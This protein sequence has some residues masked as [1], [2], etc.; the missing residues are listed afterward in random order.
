MLLY[1]KL[2]IDVMKIFG[3]YSTKQNNLLYILHKNLNNNSFYTCD[4]KQI[5]RIDDISYMPSE[6]NKK[7]I[8]KFHPFN[9]L[10]ESCSHL[11]IDDSI[12]LYL[13]NLTYDIFKKII[14][15]KDGTS[16]NHTLN[17]AQIATL[18][19]PTINTKYKLYNLFN[20]LTSTSF[21]K[22]LISFEINFNST[23]KDAKINFKYSLYE[24]LKSIK[25]NMIFGIH[26]EDHEIELFKQIYKNYIIIIINDL[27]KETVKI[28]EKSN[29]HSNFYILLRIRLMLEE[30]YWKKYNISFISLFKKKLPKYKKM[31]SNLN[32]YNQYDVFTNFDSI[33]TEE[34]RKFDQKAYQSEIQIRKESEPNW[35]LLK[36]DIVGKNKQLPVANKDEYI[37]HLINDFGQ[38]IKYNYKQYQDKIIKFN[39][40][41]LV[42]NYEDNYQQFK[43]NQKWQE[44]FNLQNMVLN[45]LENNGGGLWYDTRISKY[46]FRSKL[47]A[48]IA[49]VNSDKLGDLLTRAL[50]KKI[51]SYLN[52]D[53]LQNDYAI[54]II[55]VS[56]LKGIDKHLLGTKEKADN[57]IKVLLFKDEI[58]TIDSDVFDVKNNE[59]FQNST[60]DLFFTRNRF[61][62]NKH[63]LK[64]YPQNQ[65]IIPYNREQTFIE[66]F[67][68]YLVKE[69]QELSDYIINWLAYY[70]Q[71]LQK[72][73]TALVLLGEKELTKDIFWNIIIKE[74]FSKQYCTTIDD[75]ECDTTLVSDIAKDKLFFHIGD[76][77]T[78]DTDFDDE[79]LA[80]IIKYLLIRPSVTTDANEEI[81]I[82][83]QILITAANPA[84]YLKKVLSKCTVVEV[85][86]IDTI[87]EKVDVEDEG[88]LEDK[89][90]IDLNNFVDLLSSY[91]V[92]SENAECRIDTE[93]RETLKGNK[94]SN[95]DKDEIEQNVDDFIQ[96]IKDRDVKY[97]EKVEGTKD[98]KGNDIYEQLKYA[99]NKGYFISQDL[100]L[101]YNAINELPFKTN[102]PL[103]DRLKV[104]DEMFKQEVKTLKISTEN[105][106]EKVLFQSY[107]TPKETGGKELYKIDDYIQAKDINIPDGATVTTSQSESKIKEFTFTSEDEEEKCIQRTKEYKD[108]NKKEKEQK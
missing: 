94:S 66:K 81:D 6:Y 23:L 84:P 77:D 72:S 1:D 67:I 68:Y 14:T 93:A 44:I 53:N 27:F 82:H 2:Y 80:L 102:K 28:P 5:I 40:E 8:I 4:N 20:I 87:M 63:L 46:C 83:G 91:N 75:K 51:T 21:S 59:F 18:E 108:K 10:Q 54:E 56:K 16:T 7:P 90:N 95:V 36:G 19:T 101:Y 37:V 15:I 29:Q 73:K 60:T 35:T 43:N 57:T 55:L 38:L 104:K 98:K 76:I 79:T 58:Q 70:F 106:E 69:N 50:Q 107:K 45:I 65:A 9:G 92:I 89:I 39:T 17:S 78:A 100:Y 88:E 26:L 34:D 64:R 86:N 41:L 96:A 71:N 62:A 97:F 12:H 33:Y 32:Y 13:R 25:N 61:I 31:L 52:H 49:E 30:I 99:F 48:D 24:M 11:I 103:T 47:N 42:Q 3:L 74:I 22:N 105:G 85:N